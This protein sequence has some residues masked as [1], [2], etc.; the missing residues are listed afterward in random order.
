MLSSIMLELLTKSC[1]EKVEG[2]SLHCSLHHLVMFLLTESA[3]SLRL[4]PP[5]IM[6]SELGVS[7]QFGFHGW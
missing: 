3:K 2:R 1:I 6:S 4:I 7:W 5:T